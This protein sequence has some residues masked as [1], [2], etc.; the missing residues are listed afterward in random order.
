[1]GGAVLP[2]T[3]EANNMKTTKVITPVGEFTR[4]TNSRYTHVVVRQSK[5]AHAVY[6]NFLVTGKRSVLSTENLWIK[7][8]GFALTY[9]SS[10]QSAWNAAKQKYD[11]DS[12]ATVVGIYEVAA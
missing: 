11:W 6:E 1:M 5:R 2:V 10:Q 12:S 3:R 7:N 4:K 9:H 8:R